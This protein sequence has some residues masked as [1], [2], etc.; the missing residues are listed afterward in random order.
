MIGDGSYADLRTVKLHYD[1][2]IADNSPILSLPI[3]E[4]VVKE[5]ADAVGDAY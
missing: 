3:G 2:R 1:S 5:V 4:Y